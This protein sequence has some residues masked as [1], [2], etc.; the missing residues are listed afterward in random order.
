M[1]GK[2]SNLLKIS[3]KTLSTKMILLTVMPLES[4]VYCSN[5]SWQQQ[6]F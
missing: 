2:S 6:W 3:N 4:S 5:H 1:Q